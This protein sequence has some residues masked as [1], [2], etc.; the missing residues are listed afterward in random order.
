MCLLVDGLK[1]SGHLIRTAHRVLLDSLRLIARA[2]RSRSAV[3]AENLFLRKQLALFQERN[4]R[5]HRADD[6]TRWLMSFLSQWFDWRNALCRLDPAAIAR[7]TPW[8]SSVLLPH[9]RP[10]QHLLLAIGS[11]RSR[12]GRADTADAAASA[13]SQFGLRTPSR[14]DPPGVSGFP[15]STGTATSQADSQ[16]LGRPLQSRPRSHEPR[17]RYTGAA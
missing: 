6:S 12:H 7:S 11:G 16:P 1:A 4:L 17:T 5:P 9:P 3:E 10:G 14:N 15:H 13:P 8:R 2:L